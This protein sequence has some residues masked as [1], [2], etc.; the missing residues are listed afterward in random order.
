MD[1]M[2]PLEE[3]F[4]R[5]VMSESL[6]P[7]GLQH[8]KASLIFTISWASSN[9][10][11]LN[12][13]WHSTISSSV[14]SFSSPV[15]LSIR[16]FSS[17]SALRITWPEYRNFSFSISPSNEYSRLISFRMTDLTSLLSKGLSRVFS[18]TS[19]WKYQFFSAQPS[20]WSN[21]HIHTWLLEKP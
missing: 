10:C 16:V 9:S 7:H 17:E 8:I 19:V 6:W 21:S 20:L 1:T 18:S 12:W 2:K 3:V 14:T 11:P 5:S 13:W 15:F 4:S